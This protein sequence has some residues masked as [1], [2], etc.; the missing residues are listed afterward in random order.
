VEDT[1]TITPHVIERWVIADEVQ[2]AGITDP[3]TG[4]P[5]LLVF[6]NEDEAEGF[7]AVAGKYPESEGFKVAAVDHEG[8]RNIIELWGYKSL[9]VCGLEP[10][11]GADLFD[12]EGFCVLL[13]EVA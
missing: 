6:A 9:A 1:Y 7:R 11:G 13:E 5:A 4:A 3:E 2:V 12:A 8:L 10:G